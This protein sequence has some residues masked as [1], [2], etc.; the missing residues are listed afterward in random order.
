MKYK[1]TDLTTLRFEGLRF[2]DHGLDLDVLPDILAYR[3]LVV[4]TS[5]E[6]WRRAHPG[7][8][9]LPRGFEESIRIKFY[10]IEP[11]SAAVPLLRVHEFEN[12]VLHLIAP[13]EVDEA[14]AI[15]DRTVIAAA[16]DEPLPDELP[17]NVIPMFAQFG[18]SLRRDEGIVL[19][20]RRPAQPARYTAEV[21]DRLARWS[22]G[23][24]E[25]AVR[26]EGEVRAA[27]LDAR[28]F[29]IRTPDGTKIAARFDAGQEERI[30]D[31]L[32][33]HETLRVSIAG[34]GDFLRESGTLKR[35]NRVDALDVHPV[36]RV[37]YDA[38]ARPIW[39]VVAELGQSIP[40]EEW[41]EVPPDLS[42]ELDHY[43]HGAPRREE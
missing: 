10:T 20:S 2:E 13:D 36:T 17:R 5:K 9:R 4:E 15:I 8:E 30:T 31:A 37:Q 40:A 21:R 18:Q 12:D 29:T 23:T 43:L 35:V 1:T 41:D 25:D 34:T 42:R 16:A 33:E 11:G 27:D 28:S 14:A 32:R 7:R 22:D 19:S 26:L 3:T 6:L 24:Y 38:E 39:D